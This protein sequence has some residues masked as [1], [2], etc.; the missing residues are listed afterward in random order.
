MSLY[1]LLSVTTFSSLFFLAIL[2]LAKKT[3]SLNGY[4]FLSLFFLSLSFVFAD[5]A[6]TNTGL[7]AGYPVL[8]IIFQPALYTV[9]PAFYLAVVYLTSPNKKISVNTLLHFIPYFILAGLS[10]AI[11]FFTDADK[12]SVTDDTTADSDKLADTVFI[13][14]LFT[15][16]FIYLYLSTRKLKKHE[17]TL[18]LFVSNI[19]DNDYRW[20]YKIIIGLSILSVVWLVEAIADKTQLSF[21]F[22]FIYLVGVY[23]TGVQV[24]RQKDVFPFSKEQNE[25]VSALIDE[26]GDETPVPETAVS[27]NQPETSN[28][29][30][31]SKESKKQVLADDKLLY[32][33]ERLLK[34]MEKEKPYSDSDITLPKLGKMLLLNTYQTSYL[35][36]NCFNENFY[37]F[38]NRYRVEE[39]KRMLE[40]NQY[41]HLS[42]LGI[43]Y[44]AGF[45]SK[46][47]FNTTFKKITGVTPKEFKAKVD[48]HRQ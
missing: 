29:I 7:Y 34:L 33:K 3:N 31:V 16:I 18:P 1:L 2:T 10:G 22:S 23:Y 12:L 8:T 44:E 48:K 38:I 40:S 36:N 41:N 17:Q 11:Y 45:N 25:S 39:C 6:F 35:I 47:A 32:Y 43:G 28:E 42:I 24:I 46:T 15:Q 37:T 13:F 20:I 27:A 21:Y 30:I 19:R 4:R 14:L 26:A 5:E 9:A